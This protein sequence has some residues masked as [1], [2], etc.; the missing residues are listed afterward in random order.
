MSWK[1][2][3]LLILVTGLFLA[4]KESFGLSLL[5][6]QDDPVDDEIDSLIDKLERT[7]VNHKERIG[8]RSLRLNGEQDDDMELILSKKM[9]NFPSKKARSEKGFEPN[10]K[11]WD[12]C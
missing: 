5:D 12:L 7:F 3:S 11:R 6:I 8:A 2:T 1:A 10:C 9:D 4:T